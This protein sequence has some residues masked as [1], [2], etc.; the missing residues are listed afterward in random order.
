M[1]YKKISDKTKNYAHFENIYFGIENRVAKLL[2]LETRLVRKKKYFF[3][4]LEE[5]YVV[6]G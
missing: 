6:W 5:I 1:V 2:F 3:P 4:A